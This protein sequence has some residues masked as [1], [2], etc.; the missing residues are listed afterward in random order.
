[1]PCRKGA[2]D[3]FLTPEATLTPVWTMMITNA[4]GVNFALSRA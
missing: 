3:E 1:M 2:L 4:L